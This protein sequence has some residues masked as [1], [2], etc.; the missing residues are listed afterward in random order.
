M[1]SH[2]Q[3]GLVGD[4]RAAD[5][6]AALAGGLAAFQSAVAEVL[7]LHAGLAASTVNT[8]RRDRA[9]PK[10]LAEHDEFD[11]P[12]ESF[13]FVDDEGEGSAGGTDLPRRAPQRPPAGTRGGASGIFS[14]T[15]RVTLA[16]AR[17][18]SRGTRDLGAVEA[19]AY[20]R[21]TCPTGSAPTLTGRGSSVQTDPGL[22]GAGAS[23][24]I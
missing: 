13:A 8:S 22:L 5:D 11:A 20:P 18:S 1:R 3:H 23:E 12:A 9:S 16:S 6:L 10:P 14:R 17:E 19:R 24:N 2:G 7:A 15:T 21:R 4:I